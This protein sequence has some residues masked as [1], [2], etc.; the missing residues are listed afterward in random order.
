MKKS[1]LLFA[2]VFMGLTLTAQDYDYFEFVD[3]D[4]NV[5]P[6]ETTLKLTEVTSEEDPFTGEI[7]NIMYSHLKL[8]NKTAAEHAMRVNMLIERLDNGAYQLCF[9]MGRL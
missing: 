4:G 8:R 1:L 2:T 5:V 9:P 7:S 6:S 3:K